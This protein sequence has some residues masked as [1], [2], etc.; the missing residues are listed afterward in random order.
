M[1]IGGAQK[2]YLPLPCTGARCASRF[3][4]KKRHDKWVTGRTIDGWDQ[5]SD[6][7]FLINY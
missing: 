2:N 3:W 7:V 1:G 5:I 4:I 6:F